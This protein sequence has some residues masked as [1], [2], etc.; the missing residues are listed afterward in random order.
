MR[1]L[2][3]LA[4][5]AGARALA[6]ALALEGRDPRGRQQVAHRVVGPVDAPVL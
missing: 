2:R 5:R 1:L 6:Q 3:T 4:F